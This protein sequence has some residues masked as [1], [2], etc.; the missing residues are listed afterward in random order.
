MEAVINNA[1]TAVNVDDGSG[2]G[3]DTDSDVE[4]AA[5]ITVTFT[6]VSAGIYTATVL[7]FDANYTIAYQ[8]SVDHDAALVECTSGKWDLGGFNLIE[9]ND[10]P[11]Q[12]FDFSVLISDYDG[13]SFGGTEVAI[14]NFSV[15]IDGT[16]IH[17]G[18]GIVLPAAPLAGATSAAFK[19]PGFV[20]DSGMML[21]TSLATTETSYVDD[22]GRMLPT[23]LFG[24]VAIVGYD[25]L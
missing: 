16:G 7:G 17:D 24:T 14:A 10:T 15:G 23:Q 18:G 13:D 19:D 9:R 2:D 1:G 21:S 25:Y 3:K 8:T 11:D 6:Q 5:G 12:L 4:N 22:S 20:D